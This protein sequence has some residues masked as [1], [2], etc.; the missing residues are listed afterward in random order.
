[1]IYKLIWNVSCL[2]SEWLKRF[3]IQATLYKIV[4]LKKPKG[5]FEQQIPVLHNMTDYQENEKLTQKLHLY[6]LILSLG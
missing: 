3:P 1:M 2:I 4:T 6:W 5:N